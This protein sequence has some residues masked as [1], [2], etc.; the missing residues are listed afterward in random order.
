MVFS[1]VSYFFVLGFVLV[2]VVRLEKGTSFVHT[3]KFT[4]HAR[5]HAHAHIHKLKTKAH[6]SV[7]LI[8]CVGHEV[9]EGHIVDLPPEG[10]DALG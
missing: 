4:R 5:A 10:V 2:F 6:F 8:Y 7:D 9:V 1:L 3:C